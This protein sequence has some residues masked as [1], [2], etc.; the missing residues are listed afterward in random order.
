MKDVDCVEFLQWCLPALRFRWK[1]FKKVRSQVC[2]RIGRRMTELG[3]PAL[4]AYQRYLADHP[5]EWMALDSLCRITI[6]RFWRDRGVFDTL[7]TEVMPA[8]ARNAQAA[9][10]KEVRCWSVGCSSG[11]EPYSLQIIW[12]S[13]DLHALPL[14]ITATDT[15]KNLLDRARRGA[16]RHSS[17]KDLPDELARRT[18]KKSADLYIID[19]ALMGNVEFLLQDIREEVPRGSFHLILC[20]NLVLTYFDEALRRKT[21]ERIFE[22]LVPGGFLVI[23]IHESLPEGTSSVVPYN[24]TPGIYQKVKA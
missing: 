23:G 14:R 19:K 16:Y 7:R 4:S 1:G 8:L 13:F 6:S 10:E 24:K 2:K 17:L 15:D 18:F 12:K 20:R 11:E 22:R 3:L 5:E 9:E 21:M